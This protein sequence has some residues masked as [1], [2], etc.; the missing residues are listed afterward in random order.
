MSWTS[1]QGDKNEE[2]EM[3]W[4]DYPDA[5]GGSDFLLQCH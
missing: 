4:W 1:Q 5:S 3:G 2:F